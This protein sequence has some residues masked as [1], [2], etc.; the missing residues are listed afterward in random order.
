LQSSKNDKEEVAAKGLMNIKDIAKLAGVSITTVSMVINK[1][2]KEISHETREK[3]LQ[4]IKQYN[5]MPYAKARRTY[6][7]KSG[8]I[9][10]VVP[11][12]T[13]CY[14]EYL[15]GAE[16][17][18]RIHGYNIVFCAA[19]GDEEELQKQLHAL[20][21]KNAEGVVLYLSGN[22]NIKPSIPNAAKSMEL[23]F[24]SNRKSG[25]GAYTASCSFMEAASMAVSHLLQFNHKQIALIG[26]KRDEDIFNDIYD[27]YSNALYEQEIPMQNTNVY[28]GKNA[29]DIIVNGIKQIVNTETSAFICVG[30]RTAMLVYKELSRF[31]LRIPQDYSVVCIA[32]DI[33]QKEF[34]SPPLTV[35]DMQYYQLGY[36]SVE[37]LIRRI[38]KLEKEDITGHSIA[39][40]L[41]PGLS[42]A[43]SPTER[44]R[45]GKRIVAVGSIN[46]DIYI[47]TPYVPVA[48]E[49]LIASKTI[50]LPGGKG[51]NQ[52]VG[53][54]KLG[55]DVC[56]IGCLGGDS[57][58]RILYNSLDSNGV[59]MRGIQI[60]NDGATGKA[61]VYVGSDGESSIVVYPGANNQLQS[62]IIDDNIECL[63]NASFCLLSTEIPWETVEHTIHLCSQKNIQI[64]MKPTTL[65]RINK[66]LFSEIAYLVPN[67]KELH[68][69]VRGDL[70]IQDKAAYLFENGVKNVIVTLGHNGCYLHNAETKQFFPA[71]E[72]T[73]IDTTGAADAFISAFAVYLSEGKNVVSSIQFATYAAGLS[74]THDGIQPALADRMAV[75]M[76]FDKYGAQ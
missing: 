39:P 6:N 32:S 20:H 60:D 15:S 47:H 12:S 24:V 46:M 61:Y 10:I 21:G 70:S 43:A 8:I 44:R 48:G 11:E 49:T 26:E 34:F 23:A 45:R 76:Y 31:G 33:V 66:E 28:A 35:V 2:D 52:A 7:A 51:A 53:A 54:A 27:G 41:L 25:I 73:A 9:G 62:Q 22:M 68:V 29:E 14:G 19:K 71:V 65:N 72:F 1:K 50:M 74:I 40:E 75:E 58:G 67:E 63:E 38:E 56:I 37:K 4:V 69:Q 59:D 18:A 42:V 3:V 5:F 17:A 36:W 16:E 30:S 64:I 13:G 55:G 57:D